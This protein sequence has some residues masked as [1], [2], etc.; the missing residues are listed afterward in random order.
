MPDELLDGD[1]YAKETAEDRFEPIGM[2]CLA[3]K[4]TGK[5]ETGEGGKNLVIEQSIASDSKGAADEMPEAGDIAIKSGPLIRP[6]PI[7]CHRHI[8]G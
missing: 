4:V 6:G 1:R 8:S 3:G 5:S 2:A 7:K